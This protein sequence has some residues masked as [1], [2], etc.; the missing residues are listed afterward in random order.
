MKYAKPHRTLDEQ[1][2]LL[3]SRGMEARNRQQALWSLQTI[4]YYR[5]S[6]YWYAWRRA[7]HDSS[8][9]TTRTDEFMPGHAFEGAVALYSFDRR[10]RML[11]L[12]ALERIEVALRVQISYVAGKAGPLTYLER[13]SLGSNADKTRTNS[14]LTNFEVFRKRND[15]LLASSREVFATH[16]KLNY[17]SQPPFGLQPNFGISDNWQ[18][19]TP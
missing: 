19:S 14:D 2:D 7:I 3:L 11:L 9:E 17:D 10:L 1:L 16:I 4:G 18:T 15:E 13:T 8:G 6:G 12:D 5:L